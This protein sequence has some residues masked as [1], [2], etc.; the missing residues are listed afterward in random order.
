MKFINVPAF[1]ISFA[2]GI[3]LAYISV[4]TPEIVYVYPNPDNKNKIQYEDNSGT[5]YEFQ[6]NEV[7]CPSDTSK[8]RNYP[9]QNMK[10]NKT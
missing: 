5:C 3:F 8:I 2:I 7:K 9:I 1:I 6:E 4:P 10:S